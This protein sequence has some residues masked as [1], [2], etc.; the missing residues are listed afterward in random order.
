MTHLM[1]AKHGQS[2]IYR[3][4]GGDLRFL[5]NDSHFFN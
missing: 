2:I 5:K 4:T 1:L 3:Y